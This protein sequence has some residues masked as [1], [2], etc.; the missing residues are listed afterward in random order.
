MV[1][2]ADLF[3]HVYVL[4]DDAMKS[5]AVRVPRRAGPPPACS[6]AE[7]LT[8]ALVRHLL[9]RPSEAGFVAEV[10][11]DWRHYFPALPAQSEVNRRVRWLWGAFEALRQRLVGDVPADGWQ[12]GDTTA[13]PVKHPS[14]V[15]RADGWQGPGGL[16]AGFG[17]DAAHREWFY[18]FRLALRT[19][20]GRRLVR[21]WGVVP[22]AV[23]ERAVA[24][25]LLD[26]AAPP[27]GLLLDRGL[28]G[29]GWAARHEARGTRVVYA[30]GHADRRRLPAAVRRPVAKLRNRIET[31]VGE[32]TDSLGLAR[33]RARTFWGLLARTAATILA[34]TLLRLGLA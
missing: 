12:Q 29:R 8:V 30:H 19:D 24:D 31:T 34:H 17:W 33:H 14:R 15:R 18:G 21:S 27:A 23:D 3:V 22:A 13:L 26:G 4:V 9:G 5:G 16:V 7:V 2:T 10:R 28:L 25:A 32:L 20:L 1:P 11:R 6:D